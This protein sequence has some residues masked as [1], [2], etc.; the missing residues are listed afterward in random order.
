[1]NNGIITIAEL[2]GNLH[3]LTVCL[4]IAFT[5]QFYPRDD[6]TVWGQQLDPGWG[7]PHVDRHDG[8][9]YRCKSLTVRSI[10]RCEQVLQSILQEVERAK[11]H[12]LRRKTHQI[13]LD[14]TP[15]NHTIVTSDLR[16]GEPNRPF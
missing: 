7:A 13:V 16:N 11:A 14:L 3:Q 10:E 12:L 6:M 4:P 1:M 15:G 8:A 5:E 9:S 2:S